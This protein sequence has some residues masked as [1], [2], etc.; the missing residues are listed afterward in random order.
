M[1]DATASARHSSS[2]VAVYYL[3]D[4]TTSISRSKPAFQICP[5]TQ[6]GRTM[7]KVRVASFCG[8]PLPSVTLTP[9]LLARGQEWDVVDVL[10]P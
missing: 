9:W 6:L 8:M 5:G 10:T 7:I 2:D 3:D 4:A 1:N